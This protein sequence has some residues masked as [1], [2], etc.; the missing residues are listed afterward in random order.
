LPIKESGAVITSEA[1]PPILGDQQQFVQLFQNLLGNALK[2]RSEE[3]PLIHVSVRKEANGWVFS[4]A[5][6]GL[7]IDPQY[8]DRI[9]LIFQRLHSGPKYPGTGI[10][11]AICKKIVER[12]GGK[13]WV[14]PAIPKGTIFNFTIST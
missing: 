2:F 3:P 5:D 10:G 4:V 9:F 12:H 13:I 11:L 6:N 8:G 1:L 14:E 7:G